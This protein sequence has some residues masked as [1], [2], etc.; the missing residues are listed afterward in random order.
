LKKRKT[1]WDEEMAEE[2]REG[3]KGRGRGSRVR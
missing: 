3:V 2:K 1:A